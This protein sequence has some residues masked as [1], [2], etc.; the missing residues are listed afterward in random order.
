MKRK[1][2][3][4]DEE[5]SRLSQLLFNKSKDLVEKLKHNDI[6]LET[7][8]KK[9]AWVD[10]D[11]VDFRADIIP[12]TKSKESYSDKLKQKYETLVG[13][14]NWAKLNQKIKTEDEDDEILRSVGHLHKKKKSA[15][16]SKDY[17]ELKTFPKINSETGNE[18]PIISC[19]EFHPKMS[20]ALVAGSSGIVSLFSIGGDVNDKL[21]S[22]KLKHFKVTATN[23]TPEGSEAFIASK[24]NHSY[25]IYNL[26]KA[27]PTLVQLPQI[28][29]KPIIFQMSSDG[30]YIATSAG[31][32]EVYIICT[33]SRELLRTL[34]HGSNV[35]A[36]AFSSNCDQLYSYGIQ[37]EVSI[38]DLSTFRVVKKYYDHGCVRASCI[39]A[40]PCGRLLAT[41]SGEGIVNVYETSNI[42]T[43]EPVPI[44]TISNL[45]TKITSLRFNATTE[46]LAAASGFYPNAVKLVHIPSY[47]VFA[48]FPKPSFNL[49][50]VDT[51][52]FS[53]N[54]GFMALGNN[55][56]CAYLYRL[57][58]YKNY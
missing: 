17:L 40:S 36:V 45:T 21:H 58:Y 6:K 26:V 20:V 15:F 16:L 55:K 4:L 35:E 43:S 34:K 30:K 2:S 33:E 7:C 13:T 49:Y 11:D 3:N 12:N 50:Q 32:D 56:G 25:C 37:G 29:K 57:K 8:D 48:N 27:E 14:P 46:I 53:P 23:F 5:E 38:W 1:G 39:T 19:V 47:H 54:S 10:D 18:G 42:T 31:Y 28:V 44:K 24:T 52:N 41:G 22:F 9:P 51:V